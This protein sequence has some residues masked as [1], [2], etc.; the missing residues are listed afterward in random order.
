MRSIL[1]GLTQLWLGSN[2]ETLWDGARLF[3]NLGISHLSCDNRT[4]S[5]ACCV[6]KAIIRQIEGDLNAT[7]EDHNVQV[8]FRMDGTKK[9][10]PYKRSEQRITEV[11]EKVDEFWVC[12]NE[13]CRKVYWKGPKYSSAHE[14]RKRRIPKYET[15]IGS[16]F[17]LFSCVYVSCVWVCGC[18]GVCVCVCVALWVCG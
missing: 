13:R 9:M 10:V 5:A 8:G 11:L 4:R 14:M 12:W 2:A 17:C 16:P 1:L 18:V 15:I 7:A 3:S 6:C